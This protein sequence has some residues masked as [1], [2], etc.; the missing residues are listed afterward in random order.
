VFPS[1]FS[2]RVRDANT[3]SITKKGTLDGERPLGKWKS[4][5]DCS[6]RWRGFVSSSFK[7]FKFDLDRLVTKF[8][9]SSDPFIPRRKASATPLASVIS[10]TCENGD[11]T[12]LFHSDI[13]APS[14]VILFC[15]EVPEVEISIFIKAVEI[16]ETG[17]GYNASFIERE[18]YETNPQYHFF[19][20]V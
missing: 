15:Y 3:R 13:I 16:S 10:R 7:Q 20:E 1:E 6:H 14:E 2:Q 11:E 4:H 18:D 17:L 5:S 8:A 9:S 19:T 12:L